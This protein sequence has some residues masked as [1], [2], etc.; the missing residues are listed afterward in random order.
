MLSPKRFA[1][2][3]FVDEGVCNAG[4]EVGQVEEVREIKE[5]KKC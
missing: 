2:R 4:S 3:V 5:G 1:I